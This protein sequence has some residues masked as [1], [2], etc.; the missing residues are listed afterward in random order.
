MNEPDPKPTGGFH[1]YRPN[2]ITKPYTKMF[3]QEWLDAVRKL[4]E[5]VDAN[6]T[7]YSEDMKRLGE[8]M[9]D[10]IWRRMCG[11]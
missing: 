1:H 10:E 4:R 9:A 8:A 7:P 6:P 5:H 11:K 2:P 3:D